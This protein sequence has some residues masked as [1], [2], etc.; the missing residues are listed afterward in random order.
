MAKQHLTRS[1]GVN[2]A[3]RQATALEAEGVQVQRASLGEY[4]VDFTT[5]GWFPDSLPSNL[6]EADD[7]E[8]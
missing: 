5:Y 4:T 6:S 7:D 8:A 1:R 2:G 3:S